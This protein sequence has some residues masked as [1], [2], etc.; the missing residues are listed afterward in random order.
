MDPLPVPIFK[1]RGLPVL[2]DFDLARLYGVPTI[3]LNEQ[4]KRNVDRFPRGLRVS[5][6]P[7]RVGQLEIAICDFKIASP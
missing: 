6:F 2:L 5:A 7:G 3:R 4:V 1:I